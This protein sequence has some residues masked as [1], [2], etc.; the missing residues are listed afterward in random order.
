MIWSLKVQSQENLS[1]KLDL[2]TTLRMICIRMVKE[3]TQK[4]IR[5]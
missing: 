1:L 4:E 3:V 5:T 2:H